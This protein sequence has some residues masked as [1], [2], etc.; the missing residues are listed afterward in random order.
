[1]TSHFNPCPKPQKAAKKPR[2]AMRRVSRKKVAYLASAQRIEDNEH[3]GKVAAQP[4]CIC[5]AFG[6]VQNSPTE[7]HHLKSG[8]YS[9]RREDDKKTIPLCH[10]HHNK[11]RPYPGDK[12]K[13]GYH[14]GQETWEAEYGPDC[15]YLD[16]TLDAIGYLI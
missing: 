1:M 13:I 14:N 12:D 8:R 3:K 5:E 6:M 9:S 10:S 2:K 15:D 7:V 16:A 4:C 11:L